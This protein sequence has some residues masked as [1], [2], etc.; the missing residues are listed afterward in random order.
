[1]PILKALH[2]AVPDRVLAEGPGAVWSAQ[3][4]GTRDDGKPFVSTQFSFPAEWAHA[5]PNRA[6]AR[7]V[8]DWHRRHPYRSA[9]NGEPDRISP[10]RASS[11]SGGRSRSARRR[12][13]RRDRKRTRSREQCAA[14]TGTRYGAEGLD[15]GEAGATGVFKVN[16]AAWPARGKTVM[17]PGDIIYMETPGGGGYGPP[18]PEPA[19]FTKIKA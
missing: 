13:G 3:V 9:R 6:R 12:T 14:P 2:H 4:I 17:N 10:A 1:M 5:P 7:P 19:V 16:G 15:G 8:I 11:W 18:A